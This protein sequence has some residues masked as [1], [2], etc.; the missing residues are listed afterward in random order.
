ME[1]EELFPEIPEN[2]AAAEEQLCVRMLRCGQQYGA[3]MQ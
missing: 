1:L 2:T 3:E